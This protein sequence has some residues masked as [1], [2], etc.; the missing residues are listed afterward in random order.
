MYIYFL[1]IINLHPVIPFSDEYKVFAIITYGSW[2]A[3]WLPGLSQKLR[4][5]FHLR[6]CFKNCKGRSECL[7][8]SGRLEDETNRSHLPFKIENCTSYLL[9]LFRIL[10]TL[11]GGLYTDMSKYWY[12]NVSMNPQ[13][14]S[15]VCNPI[16]ST[17]FCCL[18]L[19]WKCRTGNSVI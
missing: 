3:C 1:L 18:F 15:P 14:Y 7:A 5:V 13:M 19:G 10:Q 16:I 11:T 17:V 4:I 8:T 9:V 6:S 12:E 2:K